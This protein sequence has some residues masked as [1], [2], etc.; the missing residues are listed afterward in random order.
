MSGNSTFQVHHGFTEATPEEAGYN[1]DKVKLLDSHFLD[2]V[3]KSK[4]QCAGFLLSRNHKIFANS[5]MGKQTHHDDSPDLRPD[6]IRRIASITKIFTSIAIMK[7]VEDGKLFLSQPVS[8]I[9]PEFDTEMHKGITLF[10]LLTHTSGLCAD[11]GYFGEPY[12]RGWWEVLEN[13][14]RRGE[15]INWIKAVLSGP[16]LSSPGEQWNYSSAGFMLLGEVIT[17]VSGQH[18]E[19]YILE[20]ICKPLEMRDTFFDVPEELHARVCLTDEW[21]ESSLRKME[22]REGKP[23][24]TGG[25]I[26]STLPDMYKVCEM[27]L[28]KGTY[29][30]VTIVGRKT[31]EAMT[32]NHLSNIFAY[33][34]GGKFKDMK[35]G[36]GISLN[37][38]ELMSPETFGHEGA[39]RCALYIDP[40][41]AVIALFFV[42]TNISWV[43]ESICNVQNIIWSGII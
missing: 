33:H 9:L 30:G 3:E 8:S 20:K 39:G 31:V 13:A 24:R 32:T 37:R 4:L 11:P 7:L 41:E 22:S 14:E 42:P 19:Q 16:L 26:Y 10:H 35:M 15:D 38:C 40:T 6:F 36:L 34:W 1:P 17:R 2:L 18:C 5:S 28:N 12:A 27:L 23:P 21:S 43:P 25:G 29:N